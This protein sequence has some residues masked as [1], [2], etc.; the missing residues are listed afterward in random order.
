[1]EEKNYMTEGKTFKGFRSI[2]AFGLAVILM[3]ASSMFV[4]AKT[5]DT[6]MGEITVTGANDAYVTLNGDQAFT[7]RTFISSGMIATPDATTATI[8]LGKAG[9]V[10]LAPK[11][12]LNLSFDEKSITGTL[13]EGSVKVFNSEGVE[14][15]ITTP[16]GVIG[17]N[18]A[19]ESLFTVNVANGAVNSSAEKGSVS[20]NNGKNVVPVKA[21]QDDDDADGNSSLGPLL[22]LA[23]IVGVAVAYVVFTNNDDDNIVSPVR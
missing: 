15:K 21:A 16:E 7:G 3:M 10:N 12:V 20:L 14:V 2:T 22:V 9:F 13:S 17:N 1:M 6:L 19:G 8:K 4:L 23:G 5:G 11:S 18:A